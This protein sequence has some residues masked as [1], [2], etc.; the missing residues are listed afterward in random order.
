MAKSIKKNYIYNLLLNISS[1]IF[2][3]IT[4]PYI[5]RVLE[6]DGV[7][8]NNFATTYAGYFALVALLGI[9]TYGVREVAKQRD[10][11]DALSALVSQLMSIAAIVT[12][13]VSIIYLASIA[14][15]GKMSQDYVIFL[16]AGFVI[17]L[18]P[19]KINWYYQGIEQFGFI[20]LRTVV[21]RTLSVIALFIFV[22]DKDDLISYVIVGVLGNI[23]AD[24]WNFTNMWISGIHPKLVFKGL[25]PHV[26]PLLVLFASTIAVSVYSVLDTLMLGFIKDYDE[27]GY[28]TNASHIAKVLLGAVTSLSLVAVPRVSYYMKNQDY[29]GINN[30]IDKSFS[31][32]SFLAFP[33]AM[34]LCCISPTFV[35][36]FFG[37][38]FVGA[39]IPLMIL[40]FL[41][42]A[43]GL[44]NLTGVQILIGMGHDKPF[45][46]SVLIGTFSNFILNLALIPLWG[47]VG[48]SIASLVAEFLILL[49]T[50]V[51]VYHRTPVRFSKWIDIVKATIGSLTFIPL[52]IF[53]REIYSGWIL[54]IVFSLVSGLLYLFAEFFLK[55]GSVSLI[56]EI[57]VNKIG[58]KKV[59]Q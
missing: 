31:I 48:A 43:I 4:A 11:K 10:D 40:S 30:L 42:I 50:T 46:Y 26:R 47:A 45:L 23:L 49:V 19:L 14:L 37:D 25:K 56:K 41:V 1:V 54:V 51:F 12:L 5:S 2:P 57:I 17:Y 34:G 9:P 3:L 24:I 55:N 8:L 28:Y 7:G 6:P 36:L 44:N 53:L 35:P 27:V 58:N 32:V 22:H 39:I 21:I 52:I 29:I 13:I 38:K 16:L 33:V 15:I 18:A 20:T 59:V